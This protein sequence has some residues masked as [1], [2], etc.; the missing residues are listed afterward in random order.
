VASGQRVIRSL[1]AFSNFDSMLRREHYVAKKAGG[2]F[3]VDVIFGWIA[4]LPQPSAPTQLSMRR[5]STL[6]ND[7]AAPHDTFSSLHYCGG[8]FHYR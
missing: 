1:T 5:G 4:T 7:V 2:P 8:G 3:D 6:K